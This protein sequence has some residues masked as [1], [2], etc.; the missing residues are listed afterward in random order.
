MWAPL[1]CLDSL[2]CF[3]SFFSH[4]FIDT[5]PLGWNSAHVKNRLIIS[6]T[7]HVDPNGDV[8]NRGWNSFSNRSFSLRLDAGGFRSLVEL[9]GGRLRVSFNLLGPK[10]RRRVLLPRRLHLLLP[11]YRPLFSTS[12][13]Q[14]LRVP[15]DLQRQLMS[16]V[17][18][19]STAGK[20]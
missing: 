13:R 10:R 16:S 20:N 4:H 19:L 5:S 9:L 14:R 8:F 11:P 1:Y 12:G 17:A 2:L 18:P 3:S 7:K 15:A 6:A